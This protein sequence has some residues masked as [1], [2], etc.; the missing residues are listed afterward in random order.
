MRA[1]GYFDPT[2][3]TPPSKDGVVRV[4]E[5][6]R[7]FKRHAVFKVLP[8]KMETEIPVYLALINAIPLLE[9]RLD[10]DGNDTFDIGAWWRAAAVQLPSTFLA[11]R[12]VMANSPNSAPPERVFPIL[13]DTFDDDQTQ[14]LSDYVELSLKL[15]YNE[16]GRKRARG[17]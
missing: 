1:A 4:V 10:V 5:G 14:S 6:F 3:T 16:R 8:P 12:A 17:Q 9:R 2:S 11:L 7:V 15:Q 13:N